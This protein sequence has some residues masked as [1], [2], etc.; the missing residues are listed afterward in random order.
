MAFVAGLIVALVTGLIIG[1]SL[2]LKTRREYAAQSRLSERGD[3]PG[4]AERTG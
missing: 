3:P 1:T 4:E 2:G